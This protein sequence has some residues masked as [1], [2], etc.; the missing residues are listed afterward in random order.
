MDA[1]FQEPMNDFCFICNKWL[2]EGDIV[3][4]SQTL[5]TASSARNDGLIEYLNTVTSVHA[6]CRKV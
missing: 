4:G 6:D 1:R 5:K 3:R 2:S